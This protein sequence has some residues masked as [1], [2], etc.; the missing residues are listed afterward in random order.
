MMWTFVTVS[1]NIHNLQSVG[2]ASASPD[3]TYSPTV[4]ALGALYVLVSSVLTPIFM[5]VNIVHYHSLRSEKE[6]ADI[7]RQLDRMA[8]SNAP[9]SV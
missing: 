1:S 2:E 7:E 6:G 5:T 4:Y 3:I 9:S 8:T